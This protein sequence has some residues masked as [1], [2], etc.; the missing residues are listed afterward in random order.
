MMN[1]KILQDRIG[2]TF[3]RADLLAAGHD[4]PKLQQPAQ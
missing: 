3:D 2:Y 4:T 1:L